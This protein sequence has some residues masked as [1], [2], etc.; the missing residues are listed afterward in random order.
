MSISTLLY[1][2][3]D[4]S[5]C[6]NSS[7]HD[8]LKC[9]KE[10]TSSMQWISLPQNYPDLPIELRPS[11]SCETRGTTELPSISL[12]D[13]KA[14]KRRSETSLSYSDNN[15]AGGDYDRQERR[16]RNKMAS[17][18][19]RAKRNQET[20]NMRK[21]VETLKKQNNYL[22]QQLN[23]AYSDRS[24]MCAQL[25]RLQEYIF[26]HKKIG[27]VDS[28]PQSPQLHKDHHAIKSNIEEEQH[29]PRF[30]A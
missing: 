22:Q 29:Y 3:S 14:Y 5:N 7:H 19:Y 10:T 13:E 2:E 11:R 26:N 6:H 25:D 21:A 30:N 8:R 9:M 20:A 4:C 15:I 28:L 17:A 1:D 27:S 18:K 16:E 24:R 12:L 23:E